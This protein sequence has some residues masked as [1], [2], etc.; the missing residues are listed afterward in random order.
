MLNFFQHLPFSPFTPVH[1]YSIV[2]G[3]EENYGS[4]TFSVSSVSQQGFQAIH[5]FIT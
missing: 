4:L 5:I 2:C 1:V 3:E